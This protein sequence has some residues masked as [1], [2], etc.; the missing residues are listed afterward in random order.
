MKVGL[1]DTN[2]FVSL[3]R[4]IA[5]N[6]ITYQLY[7]L[8][9]HTRLKAL[10]YGGNPSLKVIGGK[11]HGKPRERAAR[12]VCGLKKPTPSKEPYNNEKGY[13]FSLAPTV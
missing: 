9:L 5:F 3:Y 4:S 2:I 13:F 7:F 6:S 1:T 10:M 8:R 12:G 11:F